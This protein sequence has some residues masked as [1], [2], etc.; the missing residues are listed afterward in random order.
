MAD[1]FDHLERILPGPLN[2]DPAVIAAQVSAAG[3][4][5]AA[6][7]QGTLTLLAGLLAVTAA[8]F[9][10]KG[11]VRQVKLNENMHHRRVSSLRHMVLF[12]ARTIDD[13][14]S[15]RIE[16]IRSMTCEA[17]YVNSMHDHQE[18]LY[19][20]LPD[21]LTNPDRWELHS[22]LGDQAF[23]AILKLSHGI[24]R[25]NNLAGNGNK[26]REREIALLEEVKLSCGSVQS[27]LSQKGPID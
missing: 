1:I 8:I 15:K 23:V 6:V 7:I 21:L 2:L 17:A 13:L 14:A 19:L 12:Y 10:Y 25:H 20:E 27:V 4:I 3:S 18:R 26:K 11:A 16:S 22:H 9:A 5:R 24:T